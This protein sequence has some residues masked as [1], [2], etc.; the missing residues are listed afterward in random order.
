LSDPDAKVI[1]VEYR[2]RL[3]RA[4]P[5]AQG[6][7]IVVVDR[8]ERTD[9]V[10]RDVIEA[11]TGMCARRSGRRDARERAMRALTAEREPGHAA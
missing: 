5:W 2:D 10:V 4:A 9:D 6:W 8:A 3:A 11:L 7:R 1:I